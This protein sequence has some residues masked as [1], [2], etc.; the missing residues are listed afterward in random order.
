MG[1]VRERLRQDHADLR[2]TVDRI[3]A[4]LAAPQ[5]QSGGDVA[6]VAQ[7]PADVASETEARELDVARFVMFEARIGSIEDALARLERGK[8]GRCVVCGKR[9]PD[10]RLELV[11]ET[12]FCVDDA[13]REQARVH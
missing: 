13:E 6:P 9:I 8:Y 1:A 3:R 12:P 11:P 5:R 10:V 4:R 7:H 2:R